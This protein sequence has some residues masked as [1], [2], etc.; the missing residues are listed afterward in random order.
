MAAELR[1]PPVVEAGQGF[2]IPT[3][4]S[5]Q[6]TFYLVGPDRVVKRTMNLGG[7]LQIQSS[8]VRAAGL[9]R[10]IVCRS[11][12]SCDSATFDVIAATPA[13]ISFFLHPSRV[14]VSSPGSIDAT[15]FVFD[16]YFNPVLTPATVDF[17]I[18]PASGAGFT[19]EGSTHQ[20]VTWMRM[21]STPHEGRVQV[22]AALGRVQES[23]VIQQVA[24]E[25]CG[26]RMKV[27]PGVANRMTLETDPVRDCSGN[28]LPDGTIVSFTAVDQ[29][30]K[31]TVDAPIKKGVARAQLP[32]QGPTQISV[33]CGV[34]VGNEVAVNGKL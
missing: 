20:G 19:R 31:S 2:S 33:A 6:A 16:Q 34:V 14:P 12:S 25:A 17:R 29:A 24:A 11:S 10:V 26:L 1:V 9:Y 3:D 21:D 15:A 23:R 18:N 27:L 13:H 22:T 32:I 30:G 7:A 8:D 28:A 4:G 5:G